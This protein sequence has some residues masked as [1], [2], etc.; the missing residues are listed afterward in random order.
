MEGSNLCHHQPGQLTWELILWQESVLHYVQKPLYIVYDP[1]IICD[2]L[3]NLTDCYE[4]G[5]ERIGPSWHK[6]VTAA[7]LTMLS[8]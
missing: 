4:L 5:A 7:Q 2:T 6:A 1:S 8:L 3:K